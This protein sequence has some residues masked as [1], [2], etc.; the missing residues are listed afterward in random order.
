MVPCSPE[1]NPYGYE[2]RAKIKPAA[3]VR[4]CYQCRICA[5]PDRPMG[6]RTTLQG[7]HLNGD[8]T[9]N[10]DENV[11]ILCDGCHKKHDYPIAEPRKHAKRCERKD[12]ARPLFAGIL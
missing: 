2:W 11:G 4:D 6:L 1:A 12:P 9:D 5:M 10:R 3:L 7:A 8:N